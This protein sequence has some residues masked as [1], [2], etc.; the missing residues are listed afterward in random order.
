MGETEPTVMDRNLQP[1]KAG[2]FVRVTG[3]TGTRPRFL[4]RYSEQAIV[5]NTY[6]VSVVDNAGNS[7][8]VFGRVGVPGDTSGHFWLATEDIELC[9]NQQQG[10]DM[11]NNQTQTQASA[12][13][14]V[15][16][17]N[18][19]EVRAGDEIIVVRYV[20]S[21]SLWDED[22]FACLRQ[23][24]L[25]VAEVDV[26]DVS[27][28]VFGE[29]IG[30]HWWVPAA[31][32]QSQT[33]PNPAPP[34]LVAVRRDV[35]DLVPVRR[36]V[37]P[38]VPVARQE[39]S[40]DA[41]EGEV[42]VPYVEGVAEAPGP[43]EGSLQSVWDGGGESRRGL[44]GRRVIVARNGGGVAPGRTVGIEGVVTNL[45]PSSL[46]VQLVDHQGDYGDFFYP[47]SCLEFSAT[48]TPEPVGVRGGFNVGD[49]VRIARAVYSVQQLS[50]PN[51]L[52]D[53]TYMAAWC[54]DT[55]D[56]TLGHT[57]AVTEISDR[58]GWVRVRCVIGESTHTWVYSPLSLEHVGLAVPTLT[59]V[60]RQSQP[61]AP[62]THKYVTLGGV[63][64]T[65]VVLLLGIRD[66][67]RGAHLFYQV[68]PYE[69]R[70]DVIAPLCRAAGKDL[71]ETLGK[72][73]YEVTGT[74]LAGIRPSVRNLILRVTELDREPDEDEDEDDVEQ[75]TSDL[76]WVAEYKVEVD[77][78]GNLNLEMSNLADNFF[79]L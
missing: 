40:G 65:D 12:Q 6:K 11:E 75:T 69:L 72:D 49:T 63:C 70:E 30:E 37:P 29:G 58:R 20:G 27:I 62:R 61:A 77:A 47:P 9:I 45:T 25:G 5:G 33:T 60:Q 74:A 26:Q 16:D 52:E 48:P 73:L 79:T 18:G 31:A 7:L 59:P 23:R 50:P 28:R 19:S 13:H 21:E 39:A 17:M 71:E 10:E 34:P 57:G 3:V 8:R 64:E 44:I 68:S 42:S 54:R 1:V 38:L 53:S 35:P 55:M 78:E 15:L 41:N 14:V 76:F 46:Y 2:D 67:S 56:P 32:T 43:S 66:E 36:V 51:A 22:I 4:L 24:V